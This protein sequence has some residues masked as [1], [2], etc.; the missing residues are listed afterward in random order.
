MKKIKKISLSKLNSNELEKRQQRQLF[1]G[2]ACKCGSCGQW[3][4]SDANMNANYHSNITGTGSNDPVCKCTGW[5]AT[6]TAA[7]G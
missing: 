1:G 2:N 7:V 5:E 3:A 6:I 4:T